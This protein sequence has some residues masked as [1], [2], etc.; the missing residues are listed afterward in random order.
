MTAPWGPGSPDWSP[1]GSKIAISFQATYDECNG[2][3][4]V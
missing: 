4:D 1:D 3:Y 2:N